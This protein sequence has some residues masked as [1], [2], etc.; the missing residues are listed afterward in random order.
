MSSLKRVSSA[1]H[2][3]DNT[4]TSDIMFD[5]LM[6]LM[7]ATIFGIYNFGYRALIVVLVSVLT[8]VASEAMYEYFTKK[9]ITVGDYSAAVTGLLLGLNLVHTINIGFVIIGA[10]FAIIVVKQLYGG[11][12]HNFMNPALAARCF[13]VVSFAGPMTNFVYDG[14]SSATPL[15]ALK[16]GEEYDV[17]RMFLGTTGGTIG[18]TSAL[19]LLLGGL[20]LI[21][22]KIIDFRI[23]FF[24]IASLVVFVII[25]GDKGFDPQYI[26]GHICGGGLMIG[27]FFMATDYVT[28]PISKR[29]RVVYGILLGVLTAIFRIYGKSAEG[30]SFAIIFCNLLVPIIDKFCV[31]RAFG[32]KSLKK[33]AK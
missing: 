29:G 16:N 5:V 17:M 26:L 4:S 9:K 13:M 3:R 7:P 24:Y 25:F 31:P 6:A 1:P 33:E 14:V 11:L 12:G 20:Y 8:C 32:A 19:A 30:V 27:A 18:E 2:I 23:P 15:T 28:S 21:V 22:K 10:M